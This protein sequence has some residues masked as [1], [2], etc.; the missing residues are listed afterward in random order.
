M[1]L[2]SATGKNLNNLTHSYL[3][4]SPDKIHNHVFSTA[5]AGTILCEN[6]TFCGKCGSCLKF[7]AKT[8]LDLIESSLEKNIVVEDI[9][10]V[11]GKSLERPIFGNYKV[12]VLNEIDNA[13]VQAQ[14]KLLKTLEEPPKHD[15]FILNATNE[16]KILPTISSRCRK[17]YLPKIDQFE[18]ENILKNPPKFLLNIL[19]FDIKTTNISGAISDG[20]GLIGE[21]IQLLSM[22]CYPVLRKL[23]DEIAYNFNQSKNL[24]TLSAKILEVKELFPKFLEIL[25]NFFEKLLKETHKPG[26]CDIICKINIASEELSRNV[27]L[28]LVV[29]NLLMSILE[30]KYKNNL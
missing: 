15:V 27:N 22:D 2:N 25:Q 16:N 20:N 21:T 18:M 9:N 29:D 24:P 3:L 8:N 5:L 10:N 7:L 11:V 4:I 30:I 6:Q 26:Y 17:I 1:F 23:S 12:F 19:N 28:N 13:T 14:N